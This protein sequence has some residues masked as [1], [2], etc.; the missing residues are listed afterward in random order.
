ML[1]LM[2]P[3]GRCLGDS[4]VEL[5]G[6]GTAGQYGQNNINLKKSI[7]GSYRRGCVLRVCLIR[8]HVR[9]HLISR[10]LLTIHRSHLPLVCGRWDLGIELRIGLSHVR[11]RLWHPSLLLLRAPVRRVLIPRVEAV[12]VITPLS[13][14]F[15]SL[16]QVRLILSRC[17]AC[18]RDPI[19]SIIF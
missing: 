12:R 7:E 15:S 10:T 19:I 17:R 1:P 4:L 18:S 2:L 13:C 8:H 6:P 14:C 3:L 11:R 16:S 5:A 9:H